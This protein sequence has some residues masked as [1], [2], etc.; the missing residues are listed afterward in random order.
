ME[1]NLQLP[2]KNYIPAIDSRFPRVDTKIPIDISTER[3]Y[4][5]HRYPTNHHS[6]Y[7]KDTYVEFSLESEPQTFIDFSS[8]VICVELKLLKSDG[9]ELG[10]GDKP[11][12]CDGLIHALFPSRK[13]F[14]NSQLVESNYLA[15]YTDYI[16]YLSTHSDL[17]IMREGVTAGYFPKIE[18]INDTKTKAD[19]DRSDVVKQMIKFS[20]QNKIQLSAPL[21][22]NIGDAN[23]TF[24][25]R[26]NGRLHLEI[27]SSSQLILK[28]SDDVNN[29]KVNI[30]NISLYFKRIVPTSD[31]YLEFNKSLLSKNLEYHYEREILYK[32]SIASGQRQIYI[33]NPFSNLIPNQITILMVDQAASKGSDKKKHVLL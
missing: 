9:T 12:F 31:I 26:I 10:A 1:S 20:H 27:A 3:K 30:F 7:H 2:T 22:L 19:I 15:N 8:M 6:D 5:E 11:L 33:N 32:A 16:K 14:L 23:F 21:N 18:N 25:D 24:P 29:Y 13:L 4:W 28:P 17:D